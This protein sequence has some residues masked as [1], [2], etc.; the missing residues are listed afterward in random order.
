MRRCNVSN[1]RHREPYSL[2]FRLATYYTTQ[3]PLGFHRLKTAALFLWRA[4]DSE[5]LLELQVAVHCCVVVSQ[6]TRLSLFGDSGD[7]HNNQ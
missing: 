4:A 5:K 7:N 2:I 6:V 1:A 3:L